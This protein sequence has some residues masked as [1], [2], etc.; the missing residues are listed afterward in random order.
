MTKQIDFR[1]DHSIG[2]RVDGCPH[3]VDHHKMHDIFDPTYCTSKK[4]CL[5]RNAYVQ[6]I[7]VHELE[8]LSKAKPF[9]HPMRV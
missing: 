6:C 5:V 4:E 8:R 3:R 1:C 9:P 2:C 7:P